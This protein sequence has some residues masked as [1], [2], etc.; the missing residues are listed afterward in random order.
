MTEYIKRDDTL[1]DM[2]YEM[3]GT[4]Y[5]SR[6]MDVIRFATDVD[7]VEVVRCGNCKH[8]VYNEYYG[9]S[10]CENCNAPWHKFENSV[11]TKDTD[12][13]SYGERRC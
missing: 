7:A 13:C 3:A 6:A 10:L 8:Y 4:S 5:Q 9:L 12:F 2:M 1:N 11:V